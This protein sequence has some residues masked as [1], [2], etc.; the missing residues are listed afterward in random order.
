MLRRENADGDLGHDGYV[1]VEDEEFYGEETPRVTKGGWARVV[2]GLYFMK[3][4]R[5]KGVLQVVAV[6]F[7]STSLHVSLRLICRSPVVGYPA[8]GG[9]ETR[10]GRR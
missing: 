9:Y 5:E 3:R 7:L 8:R 2:Q 6:R 1:L 4:G 10:Y